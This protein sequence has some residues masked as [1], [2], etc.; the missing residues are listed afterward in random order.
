MEQENNL[1]PNFINGQAENTIKAAYINI[2]TSIVEN[3]IIVKSLE[4]INHEG[5]I[6]V[7]IPKI[8]IDY[9]NDEKELYE[10][11]NSLDSDFIYP[12]KNKVEKSVH[13]GLTKWNE[14]DGFYE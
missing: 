11:L 7:E 4:D 6:L 5:Y 10:F 14:L 3:I 12:E 8:E 2:T 9:T 13:I 1:L